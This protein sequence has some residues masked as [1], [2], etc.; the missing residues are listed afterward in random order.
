MAQQDTP[1]PG[2]DRHS[3]LDGGWLLPAPVPRTAVHTRSI[4]CRSFRRDD[5]L[6][7]VD[8]RFIDTRPYTYDSPW[9]GVCQPG[10]ALH[11]MQLRVTINRERHIVALVSAMPATPYEGCSE[12]NLNFQAVVG[13][14]IARGFRKAMREK[15]QG[16][17]GCTHVVALLD[18]MSAAAVQSFASI[19]YAPRLSGQPEPV[20]IWRLDALIDTCY[21]Y[22]DGGPVVQ[23]MREMNRD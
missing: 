20:R 10:S 1:V 8:G 21:S 12:V 14:S 6:V 3:D 4:V 15:L 13:L 17:A 19:A 7:D 18:A 9:R 23:R 5:G 22:R 16:V 2:E 11:N